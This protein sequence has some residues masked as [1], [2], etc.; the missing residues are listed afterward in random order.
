M[1]YVL[2]T[3][4]CRSGRLA[5]I[6]RYLAAGLLVFTPVY[7]LF[8]ARKP[9]YRPILDSDSVLFAQHDVYFTVL[10]PDQQKAIEELRGV[11][12]YPE[13]AAAD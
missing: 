9:Q 2:C 5:G 10:G 11:D 13:W 1:A 12:A 4:I 8:V 6:G 7:G 3:A